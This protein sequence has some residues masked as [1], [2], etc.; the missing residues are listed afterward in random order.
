VALSLLKRSDPPIAPV[1][2]ITDDD[3]GQ[4][5]T[6]E[7]IRCPLCEWVPA[8]SSRWCCDHQHTPEPPFPSCGTVWNTFSTRGRCPGCAHQWQWTSCFACG[9]SSPH[10]DWYEQD[11]R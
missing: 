4:H 7:R 6:P 2:L 9:Q 1:I 5:N 8:S 10:D 11:S 3:L